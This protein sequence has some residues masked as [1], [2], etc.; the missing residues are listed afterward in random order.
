MAV[1]NE[2]S[3]RGGATPA[4]A[5]WAM[6]WVSVG[7]RIRVNRVHGAPRYPPDRTTA[8][9]REG[10]SPRPRNRWGRVASRYALSP[11]LS[12]VRWPS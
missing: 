4:S 11:G 10:A 1:W 5:G 6:P 9:I 7:E 2:A 3:A 8:S 12:V